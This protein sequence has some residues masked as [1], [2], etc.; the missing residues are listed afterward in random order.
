M[1]A[2]VSKHFPPFIVYCLLKMC[3]VALLFIGVKTRYI[4]LP[5]FFNINFYGRMAFFSLHIFIK[6][7][8]AVV[9]WLP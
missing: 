9:F 8:L 7:L 2:W 5:P 1:D 6:Y 3:V 4:S